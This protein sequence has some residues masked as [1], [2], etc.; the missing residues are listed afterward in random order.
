MSNTTYTV[1]YFIEKFSKIPES[2]WTTGKFVKKSGLFGIFNQF[3]AQGFC[4]N[5]DIVKHCL[6]N[7]GGM[8]DDFFRRAIFDNNEQNELAQLLRLF[9][10]AKELGDGATQY[11]N[12]L[13]GDINNGKSPKYQQST[14]KKR[15]LAALNDIKKMQEAKV[16]T[17]NYPNLTSELANIQ[18]IEER[19][20]LKLVMHN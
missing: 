9:G 11:S 5:Q 13:I 19:P 14:P 15:I 1:D 12:K 18:P 17:P 4:L 8:V 2:K 6:A 7:N 20:D 10:G 3:C 16:E